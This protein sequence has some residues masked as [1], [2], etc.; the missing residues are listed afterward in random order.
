MS[1]K[2]PTGK[3]SNPV[4]LHS[5]VLGLYGV[6]KD[7]LTKEAKDGIVERLQRNDFEDITWDGIRTHTNTLKMSDKT[8]PGGKWQNSNLLEALLMGFYGIVKDEGLSK[9][10]KD[11]IVAKVHLW[12][13]SDIT[14]EGIRCVSI[15]LTMPVKWTAEADQDVLV[16]MV[17][18]LNPNIEQYQAIVDELCAGG[19]DC[20]L[21]LRLQR[22]AMAPA[23]VWNDKTRSDLLVALL[24][25]VK[26][27]KEQWDQILEAVE[28][29]GY[30]YTSGAVMQHIQKLQRKESAAAAENGE[31][32]A[33]ATPQK[34]TPKKAATPR[35]RKTPAKKAQTDDSDEADVGSPVPKKPK[36]VPRPRQ[37]III[38]PQR[39]TKWILTNIP[40]S[41]SLIDGDEEHA[42]SE[43]AGAEPVTNDDESI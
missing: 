6:A 11:A 16:A 29:K 15:N 31:G 22:T 9:E 12:G 23:T 20:T 33:S 43:A 7:N 17:K 10:V 27:T 35:K 36:A 14:W 38:L 13:F 40:L 34:K 37:V 4:F 5:L 26:P 32:S 30:S 19:Y 41:N 24:P 25:I 28:A 1:E 3:W 2:Q 8:V 39:D 42:K 21:Q 18:T